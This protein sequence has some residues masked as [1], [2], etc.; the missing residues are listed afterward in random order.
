MLSVV[1]EIHTMFSERQGA[2]GF[3]QYA[4]RFPCGI[5]HKKYLALRNGVKVVFYSCIVWIELSNC[6]NT[7][8]C[9]KHGLQSAISLE[10]LHDLK[11]HVA[12]DFVARLTQSRHWS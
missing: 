12:L 6:L 5:Q 1:H 2:P 8:P 7:F 4:R 9:E 11:G 3:E 10:C